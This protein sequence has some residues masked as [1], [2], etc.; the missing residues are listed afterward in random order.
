MT[1]K[2]KLPHPNAT[3]HISKYDKTLGNKPKDD[4]RAIG[5]IPEQ[6]HQ[7]R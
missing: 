5:L 3:K 2:I 1:G 6:P 7:G 4:N